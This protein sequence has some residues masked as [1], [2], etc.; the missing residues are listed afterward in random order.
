MKNNRYLDQ[1]IKN[2]PIGIAVSD[3]MG[4]V[5]SAHDK[6]LD[7]FGYTNIELYD[8]CMDI[9]LEDFKNIELN[10][11]IPLAIMVENK[12]EEIIS[13]NINN[14]IDTAKFEGFDYVQAVTLIFED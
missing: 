12:G 6:S 9:I 5:K 4:L 7:M 3:E 10:K 13:Y 14:F 1:I 8:T 2:I 11:E